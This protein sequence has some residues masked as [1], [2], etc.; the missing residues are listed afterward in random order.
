MIARGPRAAETAVLGRL[1]ELI[2]RRPEDLNLPVRVV[3]PSRSLRGHLSAQLLRRHGRPLAGVLVQTLY[4]L[5]LEVMGRSEVQL[6]RGDAALEVLARRLARREPELDTVLGGVRDGHGATVASVRDLLDAGLGSAHATALLER[7]EELALGEVGPAARRAA[8]LVRIAAHLAE[9]GAPAGLAFAAT[10]YARAADALAAEPVASLPARGVLVHG[11]ADATGVASDLLEALLRHR[12]AVLVLDRPPDPMDPERTDAGEAFRAPFAERMLSAAAEV[13]DAPP[14]PA[15]ALVSALHAPRREAEVRAAVLRVRDLLAEGTRPEAVGIVVRQLPPYAALLRR[16]LE[17]LAVP[18]TAEAVMSGPERR[19]AGAV[20]TVLR[21]GENATLDAWL[22]AGAAGRVP[23][24]DLRLGVRVLGLLRLVD[25]AGAERGPLPEVIRLPV[26]SG[27][28]EEDGTPD[29]ARRELPGERLRGF[30]AEA[31]EAAAILGG[32]PA[33]APVGEHLDRFARLAVM[34]EGGG[35]LHEAVETALAELPPGWELSREEWVLLVGRGLEGVGEVPLGGRGGGVQVLDATA[36]RGRTFEHLVVLGLNRDL[37]PRAVREDPLLPDDVRARIAVVLPELRPKRAG[38]DEERFLFAQL[39]AAAPVVTLSWSDGD[40]AGRPLPRSSLVERL[41]R[42]AEVEPAAAPALWHADGAVRPAFEA[43]VLAGASGDRDAWQQALAAAIVEGRER[44]GAVLEPDPPPAAAAAGRRAVLDAMDP[45][46]PTRELGPYHGLLG[47]GAAGE[48]PEPVPVTRLEAMAACP[49]QLFV[50]RVLGIVPAPDPLLVLPSPDAR[51]VGSVVHAVLERVV[52][53]GRDWP[54]AAVIEEWLAC[55]AVTV[56]RREGLAL[57]ALAPLLAAGA[58][59]FLEVAR[60]VDWPEGRGP[61]LARGEVN[62][63]AMVAGARVRFR[64]DRV[65]GAGEAR[66]LTDYKTG[67]PFADQK[68]E[69]VRQAK[70]L[71]QVRSGGR[72]QAAVYA[73]AAGPGGAG[74]YVFL[75]GGDRFGPEQR[76]L[77]AGGDDAEVRE[78]LEEAV[79]VLLTAWREG[80]FVPRVEEAGRSVTNPA[81][82]WC[83]V[84]EAC[85]RS[86]S[87]FRRRL[88]SWMDSHRPGAADGAAAAAAVWW[89][90]AR[91]EVEG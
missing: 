74:R 76:E 87:G 12:G 39:L 81:C 78:A 24:A 88:V 57:P 91:G 22:E 2:P 5:S 59:P 49:F 15:P 33:A 23:P 82:H 53:A 75:G 60:R 25:A 17:R 6:V 47:P 21:E 42:V 10:A 45:P 46:A 4:G 32:W 90:G 83:A 67:K 61:E 43:A 85:L 84:R 80:A 27:G 1:D 55:E 19:R 11:F 7:L 86:D 26:A 44:A 62:G 63:E 79:A 20:A 58:R 54:A 30:L 66:V 68:K 52:E 28:A 69:A 72:L 3:V 34:L 9:S 70:L 37:F 71:A 77:M 8:A 89:L 14:P 48:P 40:A 18:F 16:Q 41:L 64:A 73:A 51:L 13:V 50:T 38:W 29:E 56:A 31:R 35:A 36:A 65:D